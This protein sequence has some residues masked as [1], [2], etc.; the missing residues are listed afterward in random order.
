MPSIPIAVF[1]AGKRA[2]GIKQVTM[3]E[4]QFT[5]HFPERAIMPGVL[6]IEAM[7]Q[8][9]GLICLQPPVSRGT[10]T[11]FFAGIDGVRW[12]RPVVPGDTLVMEMELV[13]WKERFGIAKMSGNAFVD[14]ELAVEVKEFTFAMAK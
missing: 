11:F 13:T 1:E 5:G 14:G 6:M 7:A 12:K 2:V 9:G 3:N 8:L 4:N 10:G